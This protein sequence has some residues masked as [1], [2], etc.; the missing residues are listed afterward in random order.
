MVDDGA[1]RM[2]FFVV[3]RECLEIGEHA[4]GAKMTES[5]K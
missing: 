1:T 3:M 5:L 2:K 4:T